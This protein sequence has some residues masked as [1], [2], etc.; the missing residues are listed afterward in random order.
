MSP[1]VTY[2]PTTDT[3]DFLSESVRRKYLDSILGAESKK[4]AQKI[5][6]KM[7]QKCI[8]IGQESH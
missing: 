1:A 5:I 7:M 2:A 6:K 3:E 4:T 8:A